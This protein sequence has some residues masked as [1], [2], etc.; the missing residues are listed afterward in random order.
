M[1]LFDY[2]RMYRKFQLD[3]IVSN[4]SNT[5]SALKTSRFDRR[6][7]M[8]KTSL[9][10]GRRWASNS[11]SNLFADKATRESNN[12]EFLS[13]QADYLVQEI[14][15]LKGS[16]VKVGQM[17]ALYGE[18]LLHEEVTSALHNLNN[19][20]A[21]LSWQVIKD[22]LQEQLGDKF[23]DL[24]IETTPIGT[25]SLAQ[26][27]RAV[28]K[29]TGEKV[30]LKVQY[31]GVAAAIDSDLNI[32][33][34]LLRISNVVPQ[35]QAFDS[36]VTEIRDLLHREVNYLLEAETTKKFAERLKDDPRYVV[37]KIIDEYCNSEIICMSY[38]EGIQIT[39]DSLQN[40]P[41]DRKNAIG[42][43]AIDVMLKE[44]FVWGEM[45]TDPNFGNYLVR[46]AKDSEDNDKL[47]LLD[48]GAIRQF[49]NELLNIARSLLTAGFHHDKTAM[50][51]AM[52]HTNYD[53]FNNM[54]TSV[55]SDMAKV[56]VLSTEPFSDP[57]KNKTIPE[58]CLDSDNKY[59]WA[60]SQLHSR[61]MQLSKSAI[62]SI[63]FS[64]PPKEFMFISRK[65]IGAYTLLTILDT[66][67]DATEIVSAYL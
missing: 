58:N 7:S 13:S 34:N 55:R 46:L 41:Q 5:L 16:I 10:I 14:G 38:E 51:D 56:F 25:A 27:H 23:F 45:Q 52:S 48:F 49:D 63:E 43:S 9:N 18:H 11:L 33:T 35:T 65:F 53:F 62:Q 21:I 4:H 54:S 19:N 24:R 12:Q 2:D 1:Y 17:M 36:W 31:P 42:K 61:I 40:L 20:T 22:R 66:H 64:I 15:K 32:F 3:S 44:I 37:P 30:V 39:D 8:A 50:L 26:V 28:I 60:N 67:T 29:S 6:L 57:I 47:V 59:I